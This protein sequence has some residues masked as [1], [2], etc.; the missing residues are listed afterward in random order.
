LIPK[1]PSGTIGVK[2]LEFKWNE[3]WVLLPFVSPHRMVHFE[4][5][6]KVNLS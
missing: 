4:G 3:P 1:L 2:M 5:T 6:E